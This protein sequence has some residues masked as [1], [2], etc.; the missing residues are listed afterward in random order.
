MKRINLITLVVFFCFV[1]LFAFKIINAQATRI[2][3]DE[4]IEDIPEKWWEGGW[5]KKDELLSFIQAHSANNREALAKA[6]YWIGCY[7]YSQRD[8]EAAIAAF[9]EL[10]EDY[11][12]CWFACAKAR[13]EIGQVYV[14]RIYDYDKAIINFRKVISCYPKC[15]V[16]PQAQRMIGYAL[17]QMGKKEEALNEY[18]K[19]WN[20]YPQ[21]KLEIAKAYWE[22]GNLSF[23]Q[24]LSSKISKDKKKAELTQAL[25]FY[26]QAYLYCPDEESELA[27]WIVDAIINSF[28]IIDGNRQRADDFIR[29]QRYVLTSDSSLLSE[30]QSMA[31]QDPLKN[32]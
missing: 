24:A 18:S 10:V 1:S 14:H 30:G 4:I 21:A 17:W 16:T 31:I 15:E 26:K 19:V 9:E 6:Q 11:V 23:Q 20:S 32:F 8:N 29:Y 12:D 13:F 2:V 25:S 5:D 3:L 7:Y 27:E 28:K 22:S